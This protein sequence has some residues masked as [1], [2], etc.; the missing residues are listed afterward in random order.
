MKI[1]PIVLLELDVLKKH[2]IKLFIKRDDLTHPLVS[3]NKWRKMKYNIIEAKRQGFDTILTFGGVFSNHIH[4]TAAVGKEFGFKT[5]GI[6]RGEENSISNNTLSSAKEMGMQLHFISRS[7]YRLK[8]EKSFQNEL[9][10]KYGHIYIVPE[11]GTNQFA[12]SGCEEIITESILQIDTKIDYWTVGCGTGGTAS[13]MILGTKNKSKVIAFSALK[14]D[15][16]TNDIKNLIN[17]D[18]FD[19]WEVNTDYHFGGFA[20]YK[21]ELVDFINNFKMETNIQLEPIYNGKMLFGVFDLIKK[22]YFPRGSTIVA[23]HTGG[24]QGIKGFNER[25]GNLIS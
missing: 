14:G 17:D 5:I 1:T 7:N 2:Q 10:R 21:P 12:L 11:G 15:F 18:K 6:I 16:H 25:Y 24:I 3:G 22:G 4:A 8:N 23:I 13:G 20:K 19:N 9:I